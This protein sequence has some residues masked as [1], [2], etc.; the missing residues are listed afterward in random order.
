VSGQIALT[1]SVEIQTAD[2]A[3]VAHR[4]LP[5]PGAH[6]ATLPLDIAWKA[7]IHR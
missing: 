3:A 5:D 6:S 1:V 2:A 4:I 7:D